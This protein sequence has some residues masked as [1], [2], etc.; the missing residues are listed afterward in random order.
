MDLLQ[1]AQPYW[2]LAG[3]ILSGAT[4]LLLH[5]LQQKRQATLEKFAGAQLLGR[6]TRH[7][8]TT[9][10]RLK[11]IL[12]ILGIFLLFAALARPQ[13][14]S[15]WIEVKRKG[16]DILFA[17]DT[18]NSMLAEDTK[19]NRLQRARLGIMDFVAKLEGDRIGLM[20]FAGT[21]YLMC[22][23]TLDYDAFNNSLGTITTDII[24]LGGTN[25]SKV[26]EEAESVLKN[27]ANHKVLILLTDGE[28]LEGDAIQTAKAA[29]EKGMTIYTVGVGTASGELIPL[30]GT[31]KAGF[32]KDETGKYVTS[33]LDEKS[34]TEIAEVTGGIYAPLGNSGEGLQTIYQQKLQLIPKEELM[35]RRQ[36]VPIERFSWPLAAAIFLLFLEYLLPERKS[37]LKLSLS[38]IASAGRRIKKLVPMVFLALAL[39]STPQRAL[40]SAAEDA[41][42]SG[43][44]LKAAELYNRALKEHPDDPQL[45]YNLGTTAYKNNLHDEAI[46]AFNEALKSDDLSLQEKA[47]YNRGNALFQKGAESQQG[48]PQLT[49]EK[50]QEALDSFDGAL[51]LDPEDAL[52]RENR[53]YVAKKLEELDKQMQQNQQQNNE[54][55]DQQQKQNEDD[56]GQDNKPS[57]DQ[58]QKQQQSSDD[59]QQQEQKDNAQPKDQQADQESGGDKDKEQPQPATSQDKEQ[60]A[61]AADQDAEQNR[62][63]KRRELGQMTREEAENLLNALKNEEGEL[64]FVPRGERSV[65]RDW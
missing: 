9:R 55:Q 58:Q 1:F 54:K 48:N 35:E 47:Y 27:D 2:L 33:K 17:L 5:M 11:N 24:P 43:D 61:T 18:S 60:D 49:K 57:D 34:L 31:G 30:P 6:L 4:L 64:N 8:S 10:R 37:G 29:K 15:T 46:A 42:N 23:L 21:G 38:G 7:V 32:V 3:L 16:I 45:H 52:A 63:N 39:G 62:D 26:I 25:I 53:A 12:L 14:G 59:Q 36:K 51:H 19:P 50:W 65:E 13:Y 41:Y 20:P 28:N 44:Y 22:P 56:N 40:A